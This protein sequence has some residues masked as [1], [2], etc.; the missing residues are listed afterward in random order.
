MLFVRSSHFWA[1]GQFRECRCGAVRSTSIG[2]NLLLVS[3]IGA[4]VYNSECLALL[5]THV[6]LLLNGNGKV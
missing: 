5:F 4:S 3:S 2:L 6:G 1:S